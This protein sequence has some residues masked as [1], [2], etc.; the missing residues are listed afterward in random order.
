MALIVLALPIV[1]G[2]QE[3]WRR[4]CQELQGTRRDEFE[5]SRQ[6]HGIHEE[7]AWLVLGESGDLAILLLHVDEPGS[8]L[9]RL[10]SSSKPFDI[11]FRH[12][13]CTLHGVDLAQ[14]PRTLYGELTFF[15]HAN[16]VHERKMR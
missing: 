12:Q 4:F 1:R 6:R 8:L 9:A 13:V 15:W 3:A 2:K 5:A 7:A 11:W 16:E 14:P 10:G